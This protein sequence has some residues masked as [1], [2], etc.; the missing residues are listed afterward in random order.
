M[1]I[2]GGVRIDRALV[3]AGRGGGLLFEIAQGLRLS[4]RGG[5]IVVRTGWGSRTVGS[6]KRRGVGRDR[7]GNDGPDPRQDRQNVAGLGLGAVDRHTAADPPARQR[8]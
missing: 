8:G 4:G 7:G 1:R 5:G 2:D 3:L 6:G